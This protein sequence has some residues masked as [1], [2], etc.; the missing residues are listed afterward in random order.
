MKKSSK[1]T[2]L[3][4]VC[5]M[6][7]IICLSALAEGLPL[8]EMTAETWDTWSTAQLT[9]VDELP[10][11]AYARTASAD[12]VVR[13]SNYDLGDTNALATIAQ[14]DTEVS[15]YGSGLV[16]D[17]W[18]Y[19]GYGDVAGYIHMNDLVLCTC[20]VAVGA[21]L[22]P[23]ADGCP[24][25]R[26]YMDIS[27]LTAAEIY[28]GWNEY[29]TAGQ[30]FILTY[31]SWGSQEKLNEL[32]AL[33]N[34]NLPVCICGANAEDPRLHVGDCDLYLYYSGICE[35]T[36][37]EI[38]AQWDS[39]SEVIRGFILE[40]V[41]LRDNEKAIQLKIGLGMLR[42]MESTE[43]N[44]SAKLLGSFPQDAI[45]SAEIK[46]APP[47]TVNGEALFTIDITVYNNDGTIW[48]PAD[49]ELVYV[50]LNAAELNLT[51]ATIVDMLHWTDD[52]A[53]NIGTTSVL[54][55]K[56]SFSTPGFS[57]FTGIANNSEFYWSNDTT[58]YLDLAK[59]PIDISDSGIKVKDAQVLSG[60][61]IQGKEIY[62]F[63]SNIRYPYNWD[64]ETKTMTTPAYPRVS[65]WAGYIDNND[66]VRSVVS[67]WT[68][69]AE[70]K[71]EGSEE[72]ERTSTSNYIYVTGSTDYDV[73][74]E[75]IWSTYHLSGRTDKS[76]NKRGGISYVPF[77]GGTM[78]LHFVGD[79]R[80]GAVHVSSMPTTLTF[81]GDEDATLTVAA[82]ND[83]DNFWCS[84]IGNND[85]GDHA[86]TIVFESGHVYAGTTYVDNCTAIGGGGNGKGTVRI[87]GGT[88]TAV[89]ATSGTAIGGGIGYNAKGGN[90]DVTISGGIVYAYNHG[91][92]LYRNNDGRYIVTAAAIGGGS[93]IHA[94]GSD[95]TIVNITGG[96]VHA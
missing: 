67:E 62:I 31:L 92:Y 43:G 90:A 79:N 42:E 32:Q 96:N 86:G 55:G 52:V 4:L 58:I 89:A 61:E 38:V 41:E 68:R 11:Y 6:L 10:L 83:G 12:V 18:Y 25:K 95:E 20:N 87:I 46:D 66:N 49:G 63:Q 65:G 69:R 40:E 76:S 22:V 23:H 64:E 26:H 33:L 15:V 81:N 50:T 59:G 70:N 9:S 3:L 74:I 73:T 44:I 17:E 72:V 84:A 88:V 7:V 71:K 37:E 45:I 80:V 77:S 35:G 85:S 24:E 5:A 75:N 39:F 47:A 56:L 19:V 54:D 57:T 36:A 93:S 78:N 21:G 60:T 13:S 53:E 1:I 91:I 51:E 48:Q 29:S 16:Y 82:F 8:E 94:Q 27:K 30:E 14:A 34:A 2:A 28:A